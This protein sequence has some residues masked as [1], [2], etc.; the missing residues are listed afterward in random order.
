MKNISINTTLTEMLN[1]YLSADSPT[2]NLSD[3]FDDFCCELIA[4][5]DTAAD[6]KT[7]LRILSRTKTELLALR[8]ERQSSTGGAEKKCADLTLIA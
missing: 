3:V 1:N 6:T 8:D 5:V 4:A 2:L 7:A